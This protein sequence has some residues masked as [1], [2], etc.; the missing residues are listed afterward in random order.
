[1]AGT[2]H[3]ACA[4]DGTYIAHCA[5]M[6][7]S[8]LD[9]RG[10]L[11]LSIHFLHEPDLE[12]SSRDAMVSM[13]EGGSAAI[14]FHEIP[15]AAVAGLPVHGYF[16]AAIWYRVLAPELLGELDRVL[17]L[18][19]DTI[20]VD[21]LAPLWEVDLHGKIVA[22]VTNVLEPQ[23]AAHPRQ[24]GVPE[25]HQYFNTGV[26]L[27]DLATMRRDGWATALFDYAKAAGEELI[28]PD[29]DTYNVVLGA[30]RL[31]L[32]PR[33]NCMNSVMH[34]EASVEVFGTEAVA[35][36]R[37]KPAIRHFEGPGPNKPWHYM[38]DWTLRDAYLVHRRQTPWP[39][40]RWE[41]AT[42][43]NRTRRLA[44]R[45]RRLSQR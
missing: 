33:W 40:V 37:A 30:H 8:V 35:E 32:H 26:L 31:A 12:T 45:L 41:E 24:L 10:E 7:H 5:A 3:L 21:S 28:W 16:T 19:A 43:A 44:R 22:A 1:M 11:E 13:V 6:L 14:T 15:N 9:Q 25:S 36:A 23:Y 20:V 34:L 42:I 18:D 4:A 17:Y 38:C 2:L 29:Q 39:H 27:M